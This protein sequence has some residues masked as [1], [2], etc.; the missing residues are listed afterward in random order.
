MKRSQLIFLTI[1]G[2]AVLIVAASMLIRAFED[3][4]PG[5]TTTEVPVQVPRG[6]IHVDIQLSNT[7]QDWMNQVV[8][9]FSNG[10]HEVGG[11][12]IVVSVSHVGSGSSMNR[13]LDGESQPGV[14][15]PGSDLW[16]TS[17]NQLWQRFT[18]RWA[19]PLISA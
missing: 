13:I 9:S 10:D 14:W 5:G 11:K 17:I 3:R 6:A 12:P 8:A 4:Q 18:A 15:S 19:L 7:K 16:V 1:V 2:L